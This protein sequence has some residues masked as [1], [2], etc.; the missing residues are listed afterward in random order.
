[1]IFSSLRGLTAL[2]AILMFPLLSIQAEVTPEE[3]RQIAKEAYIYGYPMVDSYRIQHAYFIN[4]K[5]PEFKA[6]WNHI[7]NVGR[8][9]TPEDTAVQTPNSDTPY[10]MAALDLR[11]EPIVLTVPAIEK[12]RYFSV[13]LIDLYT[14]NFAYIGSRTTGN[15]GGS[16]LI[17]GPNWSGETPKGVTQVIKSE[18]EMVLAAYR[19]QLFNPADLDNVKKIQA[20]YK[21]EPL[22]IF[23]GSSVAKSARV[24][25]FVAPLTPATQKTSLEFYSILN[26]ILQFCP[27]H[28][29][30]Q[31]LMEKFAKIGVGAGK[32]FNPSALSPEMQKALEGAMADAW[33]DFAELKKTQI[34]TGKL[35]SG[36]LLG[37]RDILKNNYLNRMSGAIIGIY[38]NSKVEA[39]Y[40]VYSVDSKGMPLDGSKHSYTLHFAA[41]DFPP[42]HAFWSLT[43]Y[44]LPESLLI[45][46]PINR[47]LL[48]S[49]MVPQF[50]RD[51]DGGVTF[52]V[53]HTSPGAEKEANWLPA[54]NGP[55]VMIMRLYWPRAEALEGK[56]QEPKLEAK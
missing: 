11:A 32:S 4:P 44:K 12:D 54:P 40:P 19:T 38:G 55:F 27:T 10:S 34:D 7:Q 36:E 26:F 53:Q 31:A 24:I 41:D 6:P 52:Y 14:H 45:A 43:M 48:N 56:W 46:N 22:S 18:T 5:S 13:Q 28:P 39:M 50:K 21:V 1:M 51:A 17:V 35:T 20:G 29:S 30:E 15:N 42:V 3:A 8:V 23:L 37:S 25:E 9:Y 2:L 16:F 47:Y 49:S 33:R